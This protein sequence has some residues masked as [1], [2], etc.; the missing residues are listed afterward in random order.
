MRLLR[1]IVL[2]SLCAFAIFANARSYD[3]VHIGG[4][5]EVTIV[6]K[7][8]S[9]GMFI[10]K[11]NSE[12][13]PVDYSFGGT[14]LTINVPTVAGLK[15]RPAYTLYSDGHLRI[16]DVSG[17][18]RVKVN[19]LESKTSVALVSSGAA[20]LTVDA[21]TAPNINIS[22]S[23]SGMITLPGQ[24][25]ATTLNF[26]VTGSGKITA[27]TVTAAHMTVTQRGSGKLVFGGS[28]RE[29]SIVERGTGTIDIRALV[30]AKF[31]LKL[32]GEGRIFY[33]AGVPVKLDGN[34]ERI[35]QVKPYQPL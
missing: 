23:G 11:E 14:S 27:E 1:S 7:P 29:C 34:T 28:A 33:P 9:V 20:S 25:T 10:G 3:E 32:F 30:G 24:L 21:L 12:N 16:V 35:I 13:V 5:C 6:Y 18:S 22:L 31:E 15:N 2:L 4:S 17:R 19:Q 26:S 8:D